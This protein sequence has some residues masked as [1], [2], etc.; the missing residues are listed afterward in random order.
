[1]K[2]FIE[3]LPAF[4]EKG[5]SLME[6]EFKKMTN[7]SQVAE[8]LHKRLLLNNSCMREFLQI[9]G[10]TRP[11][12][13]AFIIE[14]IDRRLNFYDD[15]TDG[16]RMM[17]DRNP[18]GPI[19]DL[20]ELPHFNPIEV[21]DKAPRE[22]AEVAGTA[23]VEH[24]S[25]GPVHEA[26]NNDAE[27]PGMAIVGDN[28]VGP[29]YEAI[30]DDS[31]IP[32]MAI[33]RDNSVGPAHEGRNDDAEIPGMAIVRD[34]SVGPA[35]EGRNDDAEIPGMAIVRDNSVGPAHEG[36][37]DDAEAAGMAAPVPVA[38]IAHN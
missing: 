13:N 37:N 29:A 31:E 5:S 32:G 2:T 18:M 28:S 15:F 10:Y 11:L 35:H 7:I 14:A 38:L 19:P 6:K 3:K 36:R 26:I 9:M 12:I 21:V 27:I 17:V 25:V 22:H 1:M 24:N 4:I 8:M 33:V 23:I 30:N 16:Y 34:N 20:D